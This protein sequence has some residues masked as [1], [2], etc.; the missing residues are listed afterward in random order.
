MTNNEK[1]SELTNKDLKDKHDDQKDNMDNSQR[2]SVENSTSE[3]DSQFVITTSIGL[4][5]G[6]IKNSRIV[7][8][9][10]NTS[11]K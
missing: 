2:V 1:Q 4:G 7:E 8:T 10:Y 5:K 3:H 9:S 6:S 11:K